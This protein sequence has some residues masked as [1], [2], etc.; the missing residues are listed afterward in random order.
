M[1]NKKNI[2]NVYR[3]DGSERTVSIMLDRA[4]NKFCFVNL[5]THHVCKCRFDTF[6]LAIE[7]LKRRSD[8]KTF[9]IKYFEEKDD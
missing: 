6:E 7:D 5:T 8:V 2:I 3:T 4:T 1:I 9:D